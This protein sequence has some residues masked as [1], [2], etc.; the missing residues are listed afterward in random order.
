MSLQIF[1]T[2]TR[3]K[4]LFTPIHPG[5]VGMYVC[6]VTVYDLC[7]IGHA[8]VMVVFDTV[9]RHLKALGYDVNYVR[10]ITDIDDKIIKRALENGES[11][12][13]LTERMITEM[14]ADEAAMN[15]LRPDMEPKATEHMDEIRHMIETLIEK[16][17][18]YPAD[19]GDVYFK[20]KSFKEYGRLSGKNIDDL[21]SGARVDVNEVKQDPLDFVLWKASKEN[22]PSWNSSWGE[23]RPGWHIECS[24]MSKKCLGN[25][26]DIHGGGMD[27]SFP[28]HENEIAQSE[29]AT[30]EHYV[31]TWMHCGFVRI[32]DEKMSKSLNNFFTIREVLKVYHPEVIRYFLL[33]SHYRSPVNYSEENLNSAKASV[34][35]LYSALE[36]IAITD[37]DQATEDTIYEADF[38]SAMNDDFNTPKAIA[39]LFELA[40][41][42]N[43]SKQPGQVALLIK[44]ANQIG[45]LEQDAESFFKSQPSDSD[46]TDEMIAQLI[47]ERKTARAEK[48]FARS[49]EIRDL[50][51]E[52]GIELLDSSEGTTWR[53]V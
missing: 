16:G 13:S 53:R 40:K 49:D 29:C 19:N 33:S 52:Q 21:E 7:H 28:H 18:A 24:A 15:V 3:T 46:L 17:F 48:N 47:K 2:E 22:E 32:D 20:V 31:N 36:S 38:M 5:K 1:N 37:K 6:G 42:V 8:R 43:K 34:G 41:E 44:L 30:G 12:Q 25:H 39:V 9:V 35:R 23:G 10:N 4:E 51:S 45:L 11:I 26:F 14:H 27:L 50:L